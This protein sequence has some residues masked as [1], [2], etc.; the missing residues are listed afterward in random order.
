MNFPLVDEL[1]ASATPEGV[2]VEARTLEGEVLRFA[3][4]RL[5]LAA[6]VATLLDAGRRVPEGGAVAPAARADG[7]AGPGAGRGV[8]R[9]RPQLTPDRLVGRQR[10]HIQ[11]L[12]HPRP[13]GDD[14]RRA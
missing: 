13:G 11:Q 4:H 1:R 9:P 12:V 3:L 10:R 2:L 7:S 5:T 8:S 6:V 14:L